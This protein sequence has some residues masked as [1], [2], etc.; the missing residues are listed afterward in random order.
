MHLRQLTRQLL[1]REVWKQIPAHYRRRLDTQKVTVLGMFRRNSG[2][3]AKLVIRFKDPR[4]PAWYVGVQDVW[5]PS[6]GGSNYQVRM[7][8][9]T[10]Q[11]PTWSEYQH[12]WYPSDSPAPIQRL[13]CSAQ[14]RQLA[15]HASPPGRV[16]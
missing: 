14:R 8:D 4:K 5:Q 15:G 16:V 10:R 3:E 11:A 9:P 7:T 6:P 1:L 13:H 2:C 12:E